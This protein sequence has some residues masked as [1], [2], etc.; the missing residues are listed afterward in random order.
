MPRVLLLLVLF[1]LAGAFPLRADDS[2][3]AGYY[4]TAVPT[5]W[6]QELFL[7]DQDNICF[8]MTE[9]WLPGESDKSDI[10]YVSC[11]WREVNDRVVLEHDGMLKVLEPGVWDQ[12]EVEPYGPMRGL[13][14]I[15]PD[16]P[17]SKIS[18]ATFWRSE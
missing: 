17:R 12:D 5:E 7:L 18:S 11:T 4:H 3:L 9:N 2:P 15:S 16:D 8:I 14:R 10:R 13:Q 6:R 1:V